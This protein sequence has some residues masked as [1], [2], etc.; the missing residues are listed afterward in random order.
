MKFGVKSFI[1]AWLVALVQASYKPKEAKFLEPKEHKKVA[2]KEFLH[3]KG[4][5]EVQCVGHCT[6]TDDCHSVNH[7]GGDQICLVIDEPLEGVGDSHLVDARG[8]RYFKKSKVNQ[9]PRRKEFEM[10]DPIKP[11]T[12]MINVVPIQGS[13]WEISLEA[14]IYSRIDGLQNDIITWTTGEPKDLGSR[15]PLITVGKAADKIFMMVHSSVHRNYNFQFEYH[16]WYKFEVRQAAVGM[17]KILITFYVDG[18]ERKRLV[19]PRGAF[20]TDVKCFVGGPFI[21]RT[22]V[23]G[24]IRNLKFIQS[25][26][27]LTGFVPNLGHLI[28]TLNVW[29]KEWFVHLNLTIH[30]TGTREAPTNSQSNVHENVLQFTTGANNGFYESRIPAIYID[31]NLQDIQTH[32]YTRTSQRELR[33]KI[34]EVIYQLGRSYNISIEHRHVTGNQFQYH[35]KVNENE[36]KYDDFQTEDMYNVKVYASNPWYRVSNATI[37]FLEYG[38]LSQL[39]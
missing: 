6:L 31:S 38:P 33:E 17:N 3:L 5:S 1:I 13:S 32:V 11:S 29:P 16:K 30:A 18:K 12:N 14:I 24:L 36:I 9:T 26:E 28:E 20:F 15:L 27:K 22:V 34:F 37:H 2:G 25:R 39:N 4:L 35:I 21:E 23:N 10:L 7:H 19:Q 8:W